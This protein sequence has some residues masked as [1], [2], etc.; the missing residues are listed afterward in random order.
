[1]LIVGG[2]YPKWNTRSRPSP[3]GE[4]FLAALQELSFGTAEWADGPAFVDEFELAKRHDGEA[5]GAPDWAVLWPERVWLV[6]L[7]TERS[8]HRPGQIP[9]YFELARH[10]HPACAVDITYL[11]PPLSPALEPSRW[12]TLHSRRAA[13]GSGPS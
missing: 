8:S 12:R 10:H 9:G 7:K 1:M 5:G 11:T 4:R 2:P 3:A 6:E 13:R